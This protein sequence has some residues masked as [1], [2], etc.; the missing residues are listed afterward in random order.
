[1]TSQHPE[2]VALRNRAPKW[3]KWLCVSHSC[4][5]WQKRRGHGSGWSRHA[6]RAK[7]VF[8]GRYSWREL[9]AID[10]VTGDVH[11]K[12]LSGNIVIVTQAEWE[13]E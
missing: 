13:V 9:L 1:M 6:G 7:C 12:D 4:G 8:I 3:A 5:W 2:I 11:L 10:L